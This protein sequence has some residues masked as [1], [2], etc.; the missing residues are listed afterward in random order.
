ML[1]ILMDHTEW[2]S[3]HSNKI[4]RQEAWQTMWD[5]LDKHGKQ[6]TSAKVNMT[7]IKEHLEFAH[8]CKF[9]GNF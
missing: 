4:V 9:L 2:F 7:T 5:H 6:A 1:F 8:F 3:E